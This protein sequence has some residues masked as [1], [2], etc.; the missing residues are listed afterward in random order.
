MST[1]YRLVE[2]LADGR[3]HSG[4]WLGRRLGMSRA[5]VWKQVKALEETGLEVFAVRGKGYRLATPFEPLRAEAIRAA[6]EADVAA[7]FDT[8]E[9]FREIDSTSDYLRKQEPPFGKTGLRACAAEWQRAGRGRR[10]RRWVSPW[11]A[12]LYLSLSRTLGGEVLQAGGLSL[13]AA[14]AVAGTL[15]GNG[16]E[17]LGLKWPNDIYYR[18]R[19]LAGILLDLCGESGGPYQ[20]VIGTGINLRMPAGAA[21]DIDQPWADL[22][23]AGVVV[24]RN[25]LA[26]LVLQSLVRAIDEFAKEGLSAFMDEWRRMDLVTGRAV[27]L[28][29]D[30]GEAISGVAC[31]IDERGAILIESAGAT[32][33]YHAGEVSLRPGG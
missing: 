15:E 13:A 27:T 23:Q 11:G 5:A 31:G 22:S 9:V 4:E 2:L 32:R 18:G 8:I 29:R 3:F 26:G 14:V 33:S 24:E 16:I 1:R 17:G 20:V 21:R 7:R 25:R 30:H 12:S 10:G 19:K 6:L 28:R